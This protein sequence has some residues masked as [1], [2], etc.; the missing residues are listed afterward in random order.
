MRGSSANQPV[1]QSAQVN[2]RVEPKISTHNI[3]GYF[4]LSIPI[5][6]LLSIIGYKKYRIVTLRRRIQKLERLWHIDI[7]KKTH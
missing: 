5:V 7:D 1:N 2:S 6:L 4:V 3:A